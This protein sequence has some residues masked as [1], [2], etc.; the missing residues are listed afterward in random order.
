MFEGWVSNKDLNPTELTWWFLVF[1]VESL[2]DLNFN[3]D[4]I[5]EQSRTSA[6]C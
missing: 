2:N 4:I 1:R 6:G 5:P 3:D